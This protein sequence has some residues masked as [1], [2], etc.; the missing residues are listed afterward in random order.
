MELEALYWMHD[1]ENTFH[2]FVTALPALAAFSDF[3]ALAAFPIW[4]LSDFATRAG[5]L[6]GRCCLVGL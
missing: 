4:P 5:F 6:V 1:V 3:P 2:G